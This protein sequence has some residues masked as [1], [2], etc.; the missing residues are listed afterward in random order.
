MQLS[1]LG[2]IAPVIIL[3]SI[4]F[5]MP[6]SSRLLTLLSGS[7]ISMRMPWVSLTTT[8]FSAF[9]AAATIPAALSALTFSFPPALSRATGAITGILPAVQSV[10]RRLS[11]TLSTVPTNPRSS[12]LPFSPGK[13][14]VVAFR[15]QLLWECSAMGSHSSSVSTSHMGLLTSFMRV[16]S[17]ILRVGSSV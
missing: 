4:I 9:T 8:S 1:T 11:F 3:S 16:C 7:L 5:L 2:N 15:T 13:R 14:R 10:V 6:V 12:F 17:T